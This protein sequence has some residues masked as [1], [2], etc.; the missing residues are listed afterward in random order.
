[1]LL[2]NQFHDALPGTHITPVYQDL[3]R[4]Y[5]QIETLGSEIR[6]TAAKAILPSAHFRESNPALV[7]LNSLLHPRDDYS[8]IPLSALPDGYVAVDP[9]GVPLPQ[10]KTTGLDGTPA[11]I[12]RL[13]EIPPVGYRVIR[14]AQRAATTVPSKVQ[15]TPNT[16][17]NALLRATF[18]TEGELVS[19]WDKAYERE[20]I[21]TG[22]R[23]NRFQLF[24]DTPGKYD[25]W[26]IVASYSEHEVAIPAGGA[27]RIEENGPLRAALR[28]DKPCRQSRIAQRIS[29][30][31]N[32]RQLKFE[33]RIDWSERQKLLKVAFPVEINAHYATYD[34]AFGNMARPNHRN[35]SY[36]AARFE[37][38]AHQWMDLS[39]GDY[40]VSLL[41]D[42]KY[43]HEADAKTMR[44][45][46]LKGSI[47]PDPYADREPHAF[48]YCLYPHPGDWRDAQTI[49]AALNLNQPLHV[50]PIPGVPHS[51]EAHSFIRC[52]APLV[53]RHNRRTRAKIQFE[54]R[55]RAAWACNLMEEPEAELCPRD[56]QVE[57]L[58]KPY[59]II[60]LRI[61]LDR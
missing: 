15:A 27:L 37:V 38:P 44:L 13:P 12:V 28:L 47:Y 18:N 51:A 30:C 55:V 46:L 39:Q 52:D 61:A 6:D 11:V 17:E 24:E 22:Q 54:R 60:T 34:I 2:T 49:H 26:D 23:G 57:V 56:E 59:E 48:T 40:G 41:N 29:L 21:L 20:V 33:T 50:L 31:A 32:S 42:C 36:D 4:D 9:D 25:A 14:S 1:M 45:T 58:L 53:E 5:A 7:V 43:G 10:Q 8:S 3:L 19:L 35:T 16:L